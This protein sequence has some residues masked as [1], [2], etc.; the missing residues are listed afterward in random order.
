MRLITLESFSF[1]ASNTLTVPTK[2]CISIRQFRLVHCKRSHLIANEASLSA[3][4]TH[5]LCAT[6]FPSTRSKFRNLLP[7]KDAK[8]MNFL[9]HAV[10]AKT[11]T[12]GPAAPTEGDPA[13]G[14]A[15]IFPASIPP[16]STGD[17]SIGSLPAAG[18]TAAEDGT[19]ASSAGAGPNDSA[20]AAATAAEAVGVAS[21]MR[22]LDPWVPVVKHVVKFAR[23]SLWLPQV[24]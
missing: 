6:Q 11:D 7:A 2:S 19:T 16:Q 20:A 3:R 14:S 15:P 1:C 13:Q 23:K 4:R 22:T 8:G 17:G 12:I 5:R 21:T 10:N 9:H 24:Q 18:S